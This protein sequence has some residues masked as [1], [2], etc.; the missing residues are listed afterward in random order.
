MMRA[1]CHMK[2]LTYKVQLRL[3]DITPLISCQ[4]LI[5]LK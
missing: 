5:N 4:K 2:V 3:T 1:Q